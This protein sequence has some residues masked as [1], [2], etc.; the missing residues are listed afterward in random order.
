MGIL[1]P[2]VSVLP[3][4]FK[5]FQ[6]IG[7]QFSK[8]RYYSVVLFFSYFQLR[9]PHYLPETAVK[10][11]LMNFMITTEGLQDQLLGIVVA[12]ERP[13]LEDEKNK[14]ILQGASNKKKLKELE[15]QI[16]GVLSSSEGNILE[17]ESAIQVLNSSKELS[18]EIAEKQAYFEETEQKI[19][20]AR[21]GYVPIA[22]HSTI[23]FFS[24]ADLANIDPMYQYSLTWFINLFNM[25]IDNSE[26]SEDLD[27]RLENL[28]SYLTYSLYCNVCRSLFEKDKLLFSFLLAVNMARHEGQLNE[29]EWRF[30]LTGGVGLDNPHTNP[31]DWFP[32]KNWDELCRLDDV[33]VFS[34]IRD[35][36]CSKIGAWKMI[37]DSGNP[38]EQPLPAELKHIRT[39]LQQM[40]VLRVLRPDKIVPAIQNYVVEKMGKEYVEP[41]PFDLP[42]TFSD[43]SCTV[44]LL[45]VLSPGADPM[46]ALLKFAEDMGFGGSKFESLSLGQGQGPIALRMIERGIKE[47]TW[48]LLQNCHLAPSWMGMLEKTVE[49]L[50][51]D[52]THPDFRLWLTSYPSKDFPVAILQNG[53]KMT[54]EPPK[55]LRFNLWRSY[56]SDPISNQEFFQSCPNEHAWKKML[57]GLVFFHAIVQE[58]RKF[59]PL[60]W[61]TPYEF[62]ETDLRISVQQLHIF[63]E[64]YS[65]VQY[66]ALRYLTG[67][68]NY[69]GRVTD[70]WDRRTLKTVLMRFYCPAIVEEPTYM[71]DESGIYYVPE[72]THY[73][74]YIDYIKSLPLNPAPSVFGMHEN[75]DITKDQQETNLMFTNIL[76]TQSKGTSSAGKSVDETVD[77]VAA[78]VLSRLPS[79]FNT[80]LVLRKYPTRYEQSMNT[81][82]VQ[83]MVRF[84]ALL[85]VIRSSLS[86]IRLAIKG[87]VVMSADLEAVVAAILASKIPEMWMSK[88]YPS[89]KPLGSYVNDFLARLKFL[90]EWYDQEAPPV[91]WMSGFFFTQ[92]FLTGVQQNYARKH[93]IPIDL[94]SFEFEVLEDQKYTTAPEEG[95][96]ITGL[97]L[98]GARWDRKARQLA[99]S[100]PKVLQDPMPP[101]WLQPIKKSDIKPRPSYTSP[102]YKTSE[103]R[104]VL[105]TTGH[106]TN[107]VLPMLLSSDKPESHW[108][109]RGVALL[110][111]LDD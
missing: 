64:Q 100:M 88:S 77:E 15:D 44:P 78:D 91:F 21:L 60:G 48:V 13:E 101:I 68:C 35:H 20:E 43:S 80:E 81:V 52:T 3:L 103:R 54:N 2:Y 50:N 56:L 66:E 105:S 39:R 26:K 41:P 96:Y 92:A 6:K 49:E 89:L 84:N 23:L 7:L 1:Y 5:Y 32:A 18:N 58:R 37:Y 82:L 90:Q 53:V 97:F 10:V 19:D 46:V 108:I 86:D 9:N 102:V 30:L 14:L 98:D 71:L 75:A 11:T 57:F 8:I 94:L 25:G 27:Q 29:Q 65:D 38:H 17:D 47:G 51:P 106:S 109:M 62:N 83:E 55:G 33:S 111:Q 99:E 61:N 74:G 63:L 85:S 34:G 110:C 4:S 42:G 22:V 16:L 79:N 67:E 93:T 73:E 107:F 40:C 95:A 24:I 87:L 69:G 36:F 31:A 72:D 104:G 28:R 12:R 45:F 59:G 76:L 70:E